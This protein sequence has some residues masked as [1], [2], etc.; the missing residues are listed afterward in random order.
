MSR[1]IART[2]GSSRPRRAATPGAKF[3]RKTSLRSISRSSAGRAAGE[4]PE[5]ESAP[6]D[7]YV[8]V[9]Y[10]GRWFWIPDTDIQSKYSF[11]FVMLLFSI[12]G[13]GLKAAAPVVT[14]PAQ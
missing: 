14:V 1:R 2:L 3:C 5:G 6:P 7:A 8:A 12:S 11:A 9:E 4:H 10:H 13:T